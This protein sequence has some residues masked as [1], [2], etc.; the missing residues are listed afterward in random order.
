ARE[1]VGLRT[2]EDVRVR[3]G[4]DLLVRRDDGPRRDPGLPCLRRRDELQELA[5]LG[6]VLER[7]REVRPADDRTVERSLDRRPREEGDRLSGLQAR[8][9]LLKR[10]TADE[11]TLEVELRLRVGPEDIADPADK[12]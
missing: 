3:R 1:L 4:R 8:I 2:P 10:D 9:H 7:R 12:A 6:R 11:P 5:H